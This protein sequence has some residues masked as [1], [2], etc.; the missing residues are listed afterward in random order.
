MAGLPD[1]SLVVGGN[2]NAPAKELSVAE[3]FGTARLFHVG[4]DGKVVA[5]IAPVG[6]VSSPP[7]VSRNGKYIAF[8]SKPA[9]A[10]EGPRTKY[11]F[12]ILSVDG[13]VKRQLKKPYFPLAVM[14][15]GAALVISSKT[16]RDKMAPVS[17][18]CKDGKTVK[19]VV[20]AVS[21]TAIGKSV[22]Y[23]T[24]KDKPA[25]RTIQLPTR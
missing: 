19:E 21:A 25:I 23:A 15:D 18:V 20:R 8:Q 24:N 17:W 10:P 13:K 5:D 14:D 2:P 1:G 16:D 7:V 9:D 11:A 12:T 6:T 4:T 22:I 3:A